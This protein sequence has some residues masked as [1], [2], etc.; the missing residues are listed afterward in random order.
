[1]VVILDQDLFHG[2]LVAQQI[3]ENSVLGSFDVDLQDVQVL[4]S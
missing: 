1:M 3:V 4:V 2:E